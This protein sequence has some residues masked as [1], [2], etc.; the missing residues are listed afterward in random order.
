VVGLCFVALVSAGAA[1]AGDVVAEQ[2]N[3]AHSGVQHEAGL[4]APFSRRWQVSLPGAASSALIAQGKVFVRSEN[5]TFTGKIVYALDALDG[6]T[7]W[8]VEIPSIYAFGGAAYDSARLFVLGSEGLLTALDANTGALLWAINLPGQR[9]FSAAPTAGGGV[10]YAAGSGAGGTAY[11]VDEQTGALLQTAAVTNGDFSS[12]T[13]ADGKMFVAYSCGVATAFEQVTLARLWD[14][15]GPCEGGGGITAPYAN[16]RLFVAD[17][18]GNLILDAATGQPVGTF[19]GGT[20]GVPVVENNTAWM[21]NDG[22]LLE[23]NL[24]TGASS[25]SFADTAPFWDPP[26]VLAS[27][28]I[29]QVIGHSSSGWA[30]ALQAGTGRTI[31]RVRT[32]PLSPEWGTGLAAGGGI[33][34]MPVGKDVV[35]F[36][37]QAAS[38]CDL[39]AYPTS[40]GVLNLKNANLSG[41]YLPNANLSGANV[42]SVNA[43]DIYLAGANLSGANLSQS[44]FVR[45]TLD[46]ANLTGAKLA[47][48]NLRYATMQGATLTGVTWQQTT[49]PDGT[50]S[51]AN[52]GTCIGH[53]AS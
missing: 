28:A 47:G 10:V 12:P 20:V 1:S 26:I 39:S 14:H 36:Q 42:A 17:N 13:L 33:L 18:F 44:A 4:T 9:I 15:S 45:A 52:G 50:N 23:Q 41:C 48:T 32:D 2:I 53:L 43:K 35:A 6:H 51:N 34:V 16:G 19:G 37:P 7:I 24:A 40:K 49:C 8:S 30:Y 27:G 22:Q 31:W 46:G 21:V 11:A 38:S 25:W 29:R 5:P 3:V